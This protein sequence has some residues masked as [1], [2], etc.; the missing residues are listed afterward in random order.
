VHIEKYTFGKIRIDGFDYSKD[1][2][3]LADEIVS[4]W[5][6]EAGGHVF[7]PRD[8]DQLLKAR[9]EAAVL[10]TGYFGLVRVADD[11]YSAFREIGCKV[12]VERTKVAVDIYNRLISEGR[13]VTAALHI[14]C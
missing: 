9:P 5:W 6:R 4:P 14:T 3:L 2:I 1:V 10:G 11:T 12:V 8:L 7:A 13:D